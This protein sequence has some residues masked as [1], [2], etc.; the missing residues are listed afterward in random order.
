MTTLKIDHPVHTLNNQLLLPPGTLLSS[1]ALN[2]MISVSKDKSYQIIP[3]LTYDTVRQDLVDS[4]LCDPYKMVFDDQQKTAELLSF[5]E[6]IRTV[7]PILESLNY[8]KQSDSYTYLH[9]LKVFALSTLIS[10]SLVDN[11]QDLMQESMAGPIHDFGKICVPLQILKKTKPLTRNERGILEHHA[12]AG[13]VLLSYYLKDSSSFFAKVA[14][15]HHERRDGSG[16]PLGIPLTDRMLEII[17]VSDVYD[18][19]ISIRPYRKTAYDNRTALEEITKMAT[20][21]KLGWDVVKT[22]VSC[23]RSTK[24]HYKECLVSTEERGTP[25]KDNNYGIIVDEDS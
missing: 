2:E 15:E 6:K 4:L 9:I 21:G 5:M 16:Y 12:L 1:E 7:L 13:Y 18:A 8:F 24:P 3:I 22:L 20:Q 25:P 17:V 19:L 23:N 14:K 11:Y 10:Q